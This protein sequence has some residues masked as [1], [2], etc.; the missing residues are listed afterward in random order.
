M[1]AYFHNRKLQMKSMWEK[2]GGDILHHL[3][4]GPW[5]NWLPGEDLHAVLWVNPWTLRAAELAQGGTELQGGPSEGLGRSSWDGPEG[6]W[7]Q[8]TRTVQTSPCLPPTHHVDPSVDCELS[9]EN[10]QNLGQFPERNFCSQDSNLS[11][12]EVP[13]AS[14]LKGNL[15]RPLTPMAPSIPHP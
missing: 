4:L 14:V 13:R 3:T 12:V 2:L 5:E 11:A 10:R 9:L 8:G 6:D 15:C 1:L 7:C